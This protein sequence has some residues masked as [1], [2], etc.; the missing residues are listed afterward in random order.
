MLFILVSQN[1]VVQIEKKNIELYEEIGSGSFG[2]VYRAK[3]LTCNTII[4]VKQLQLRHLNKEAEE[5]IYREI[6]VLNRLR[7]PN[8]VSLLGTCM[9]KEYYALVIEYM[10]LGSLYKLIHREKVNLSWVNRLSIA[11]DAARGIS[12]LHSQTPRIL[13]CDIKSLNMLIQQNHPKYHIK[14]CDFGTAEIRDETT[15]QAKKNEIKYDIK[16]SKHLN[17]VFLHLFPEIPKLRVSIH[18]LGLLQK[19]YAIILT[20]EKVTFIA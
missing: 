9:E 4:A 16:I 13:H 2:A 15:R 20:Q 1:S 11:S 8:I 5:Q 14:V 19:Y 18:W 7:H 3:W 6:S 17:T 12:Y 10:P